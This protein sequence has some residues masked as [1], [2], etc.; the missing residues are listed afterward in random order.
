MTPKHVRSA[1]DTAYYRT[2][3]EDPD[4]RAVEPGD[5]R[6]LVLFVMH[7]LSYL[8]VDTRSVLDVGCGLGLWRGVLE[9]ID[10]GIEYTGVESS[11]DACRRFGWAQGTVD[12]FR[13]ENTYD[14]VVCQ[15]VFQYLEEDEILSGLENLASL[16]AG[17]AYIEVVTREDWER[18]C[19]QRTTDGAIH[20]RDAAWYR[21]AIEKHFVRCGGGV[22]VPSHAPPVLYEMERP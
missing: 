13:S 8:G 16:C 9:E 20:L 12:S 3:Y 18:N 7:Y 5:T 2:F 14:L 6:K 22:F 17:G 19:D 21:E 10:P 11:A 4:T 15:S 1:F